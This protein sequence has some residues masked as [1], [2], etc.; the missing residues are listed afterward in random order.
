M[1][2]YLCRLQ[3]F[4]INDVCLLTNTDETQDK[5]PVLVQSNIGVT[6]IEGNSVP[7][8]IIV[9]ELAQHSLEEYHVIRWYKISL[10]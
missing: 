10:F 7:Q 4:S 9:A 3:N 6:N 5:G 8:D 1:W 2:K